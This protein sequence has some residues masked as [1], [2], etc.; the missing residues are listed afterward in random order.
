VFLGQSAASLVD[1]FR[2]TKPRSLT[3]YTAYVDKL[4][5]TSCH[6]A[7]A[8]IPAIASFLNATRLDFEEILMLALRTRDG[9]N[10]TDFEFQ[11]NNTRT[12]TKILK[13]FEKFNDT[14]HVQYY[15]SENSQFVRL[16]DPQGFLFS[17][18]IIAQLFSS[19]SN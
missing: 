6:E 12:M 14:N 5:G 16:T 7:A 18:T 19:M 15:K 2:F 17:N 10:L 9:I 4:C 1:G 8:A 11:L 13:V 3:E